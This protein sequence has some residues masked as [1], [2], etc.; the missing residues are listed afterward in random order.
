MTRNNIRMQAG[1]A[2]LAQA[3]QAPQVALKLL[4]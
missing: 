3:N 2:V 1:V 4:Q